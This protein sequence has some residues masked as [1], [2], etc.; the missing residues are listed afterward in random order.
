MKSWRYD[1][2]RDLD[3][4]P[5][6]RLRR[7][8]RE[9]DMT[10][11]SLRLA[12]A[13]LMRAWL[14]VIHRFHVVG[15]EHLPGAE[16]SFVMVANHSS[17][18]DALCLLA[19]LP[20]SRVH[21]SHPAAAHDYFFEDDLPTVAAGVVVNA[22]PFD[23][24]KD[25]EASL[26][27]CRALLGEPGNVLILF[28]EGSRIPDREI[29]RFRTGIGRLVAGTDIP[30]VPCWLEGPWRAF[31]KGVAIPRPHRLEARLGSARTFPEVACLKSGWIE[32]SNALEADV[33]SLGG[34][35]PRPDA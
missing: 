20:L 11:H 25:S 2:A 21:R 27:R 23:R 22:L 24:L 8:P 17:H 32:V 4:S 19:T 33:R 18:F 26:D 10:V 6:E 12:S 31:P 7:F 30:V 15:R 1:T 14:R 5:V 35:A 9:P 34:L 16:R 3:D 29:S 13:F 28:P